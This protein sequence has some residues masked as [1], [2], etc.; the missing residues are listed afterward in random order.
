MAANGTQSTDSTSP[1][2]APNFSSSHGGTLGSNFEYLS[3]QYHLD[4]LA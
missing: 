3:R 4:L 2:S 1:I